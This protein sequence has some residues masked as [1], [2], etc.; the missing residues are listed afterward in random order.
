MGILWAHT[1][2]IGCIGLRKGPWLHRASPS[3]L[4]ALSCMHVHTY[5]YINV[6]NKNISWYSVAY[7][8]A[9]LQSWQKFSLVLLA[10]YKGFHH[11]PCSVDMK[12]KAHGQEAVWSAELI[13][14][15]GYTVSR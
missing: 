9:K 14:M 8:L 3:N 4:G 7:D 15:N 5:T 2:A 13:G 11:D 12:P 1:G 6:V 10:E